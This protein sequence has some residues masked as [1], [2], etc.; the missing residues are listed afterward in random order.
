MKKN[1]IIIDS[2]TNE[3]KEYVEV[4]LNFDKANMRN[5]DVFNSGICSDIKSLDDLLRL[6]KKHGLTT[7]CKIFRAILRR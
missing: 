2:N 3:D 6:D 1:Y 5:P 7:I 4:K